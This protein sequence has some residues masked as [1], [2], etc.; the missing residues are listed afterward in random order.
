MSRSNLNHDRSV[1]GNTKSPVPLLHPIDPIGKQAK[2]GSNAAVSVGK[3]ISKVGV[4]NSASSHGG[5]SSLVR[6]E[7]KSPAI[8]KVVEDEQPKPPHVQISAS[9]EGDDT[10]LSGR[11]SRDQFELR[12]QDVEDILSSILAEIDHTPE[13]DVGSS[14]IHPAPSRDKLSTEAARLTSSSPSSDKGPSRERSVKISE[15]QNGD[16]KDGKQGR[17]KRK[18]ALKKKKKR[19][20]KQGSSKNKSRQRSATKVNEGGWLFGRNKPG[21]GA[22]VQGQQKLNATQLGT[23]QKS[24]AVMNP[25]DTAAMDRKISWGKAKAYPGSLTLSELNDGGTGTSKT[26]SLKRLRKKKPDPVAMEQTKPKPEGISLLRSILG[27][28]GPSTSP[29]KTAGKRQEKNKSKNAATRSKSGTKSKESSK[30][31]KKTKSKRKVKSGGLEESSPETKL[32]SSS[33]TKS[34]RDADFSPE[35]TS[36]VLHETL[37]KLPKIVEEALEVYPVEDFDVDKEGA[38]ES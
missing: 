2:E 12:F 1:V 10:F 34:S 25:E 16:A 11:T 22:E 26:R 8:E 7:L 24:S 15:T 20:K 23:R 31:S 13:N 4:T 29:Q 21:K 36:E 3:G 27:M 6:D 28:S 35:K 17:H 14:K 38:E 37:P 9:P 30:G 19:K 32:D 18:G 33:E 5:D